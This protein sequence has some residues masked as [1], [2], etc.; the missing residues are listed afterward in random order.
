[1]VNRLRSDPKALAFVLLLAA[2]AAWGATF[3]VVK[4][5]TAHNSVLGF[6]AWRFLVAGGLLT[7]PGRVRCSGSGERAGPRA[8][9]SAWLWPGICAP[10]VRAALYVGR[11]F[12]LSDRPTGCVHPLLAWLLF[13]HRPAARAL[14]A[15][16]LAIGGLAVMSLHG[17]TLGLGE[18]LTVGAALLFAGQIVG[19]GFWSSAQDAYGLATVQLLTVAACCWLATLPQGPRAPARIS[20]WVAIVVT[21]VVATAIAFVV[22]SWAQSQLSTAGAAVVLTMEPVFAALVAWSVGEKLGWSVLVGGGLVVVA[23][24]V[25]EVAGARWLMR[26][27]RRGP[28]P[29][30]M[31]PVPMAPVPWQRSLSTSRRF[32]GVVPTSA[33]PPRARR[34][35]ED[36]IL[37]LPN[38][39]TSVR[40]YWCR[41]SYGFWSSPT[42][43]LV[44]GGGPAR[45]PRFY[46]LGGRTAGPPA[47][48]GDQPRKISTR[49]PT[50]PFS[51]RP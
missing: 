42:T 41:C 23:M 51:P 37:S 47:R 50:G 7:V 25:V 17:M 40:L 2:T 28:R 3:V 35:G 18:L 12:R 10:D 13:R 49:P 15:T 44:R 19:L 1:L 14:V 36:R 5:A 20:E 29:V 31:A 16:T 24:L 32:E 38:V 4:G 30:P 11:Y 6:L 21:A 48:P 39:V 26:P 43:G 22:Q 8:L 27:P 34:T 33:R 46:G 45:R 9:S